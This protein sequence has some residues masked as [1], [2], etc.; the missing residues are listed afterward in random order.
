MKA[1]GI[2]CSGPDAGAFYINSFVSGE[3]IVK[4]DVVVWYRAGHEHSGVTHDCGTVGPTF[5]PF[6]PW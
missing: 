2:S 1:T 5:R 3:S 4:D 6:G